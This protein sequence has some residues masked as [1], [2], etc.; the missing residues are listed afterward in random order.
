LGVAA[1]RAAPAGAARR[2]GAVLAVLAAAV[3]LFW[4]NR[5]YYARDDW[6][7]FYAYSELRAQFTDYDRYRV[8]PENVAAFEAAGWQPVDLDMLKTW[9]F[10]DPQRYGLDQLRRVADTVPTAPR[11][12]LAANAVLVAR[13]VWSTPDVRRL[14]LAALAAV[15]LTGRGCQRFILPVVLAGLAFALMVVLRTYYWTPFRVAFTLF[16]GI[17]ACVALRPPAEAEARPAVRGWDAGR[18]GRA[19]GLVL[20]AVLVV[21]SLAGASDADPARRERRK[22]CEASVAWMQGLHPRPDQLFVV[23]REKLHF[24][25]LVTPLGGAGP[26]RNFRC[27]FLSGLWPTPQTARRLEEFGVTD[28]YRAICER[29]DVLL[30]ANDTLVEMFR[31]YVGKHY[32]LEPLFETAYARRGSYVLVYRTAGDAAALREGGKP[33]PAPGQ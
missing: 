23:W 6:R 12:P 33:R 7:D 2:A 32:G 9:F 27:V 22:R 14:A 25:D 21:A 31:A 16:S 10:A 28:L 8:T 24:E 26:P 13:N 4:C 19:A 29:P 15:L 3:G 1:A 30:V 11:E 18:I 17:P 20:A 5:A